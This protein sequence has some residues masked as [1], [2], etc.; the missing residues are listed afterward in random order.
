MKNSN[1]SFVSL[2]SGVVVS[3]RRVECEGKLSVDE[4][5]RELLC[6]GNESRHNQ[7]VQLLVNSRNHKKLFRVFPE[8]VVL[9]RGDSVRV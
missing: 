2:G 5:H 7:K 8:G 9:E 4:E 1:V 6:I 3:H